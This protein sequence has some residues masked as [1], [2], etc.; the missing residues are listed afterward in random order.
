MVA[1][2]ELSSFVRTRSVLWLV[3]GTVIWNVI[4]PLQSVT[5]CVSDSA[6]IVGKTGAVRLYVF[7]Q[8]QPSLSRA[9][10]ACDAP[11]AVRP[12]N[13]TSAD[14]PTEV[15]V[16]TVPMG[17]VTTRFPIGLVMLKCSFTEYLPSHVTAPCNSCVISIF[18][19]I[20]A[21]C[22]ITLSQ[23]ERSSK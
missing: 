11:L 23:V 6:P 13:V 8:S 18:G 19:T 1:M 12:V 15:I 16:C 14:V 2:T 20:G 3:N 9:V 10:K 4:C 7:V 21:N 17:G 5:P 22:G